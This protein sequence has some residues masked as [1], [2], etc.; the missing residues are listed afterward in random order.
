MAA[1]VI[2]AAMVVAAIA[3]RPQSRFPTFFC[4]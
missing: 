3:A 1:V 2:A 4:T